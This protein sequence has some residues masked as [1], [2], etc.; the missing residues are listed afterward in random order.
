M[1]TVFNATRLLVSYTNQSDTCRT[2]HFTH[3]LLAALNKE[4]DVTLKRLTLVDRYEADLVVNGSSVQ[5][6]GV[7][8]SGAFSVRHGNTFVLASCT[9]QAIAPVTAAG[10]SLIPLFTDRYGTGK[11]VTDL[12]EELKRFSLSEDCVWWDYVT[13]LEVTPV[14]DAIRMLIPTS[15]TA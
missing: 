7:D 4:D 10:I 1:D 15:S 12:H 14:I 2:P 9:R 5:V 11:Q 6:R 8:D 13:Y 3:D